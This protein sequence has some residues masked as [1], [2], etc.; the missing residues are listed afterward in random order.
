MIFVILFGTNLEFN[1]YTKSSLVLYIQK[2]KNIGYTYFYVTF[3]PNK[4]D[5]INI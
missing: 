3:Y 5:T 2:I 4:F 1:N